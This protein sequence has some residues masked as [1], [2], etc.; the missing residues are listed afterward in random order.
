MN[1]MMMTCRESPKHGYYGCE[2]LFKLLFVSWLDTNAFGEDMM[3]IIVGYCGHEMVNI[4]EI[5]SFCPF[6]GSLKDGRW[7]EGYVTGGSGGHVIRSFADMKVA[8][9]VFIT[10]R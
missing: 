6:Q 1:M 10:L 5:V 7:V 8:C 2:V 4:P 3:G 9:L